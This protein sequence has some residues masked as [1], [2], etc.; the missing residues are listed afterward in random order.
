VNVFTCA[1]TKFCEIFFAQ[2]ERMLQRPF[3]LGNSGGFFPWVVFD[4]PVSEG[5]IGISGGG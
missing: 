4:P 3:L 5:V 2:M 1:A